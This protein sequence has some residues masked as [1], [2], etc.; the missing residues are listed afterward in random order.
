MTTSN[1]IF[2]NFSAPIR[3]SGIS[4][5][6]TDRMTLSGTLQKTVMLLALFS[7]GAAM[8]WTQH[9][10]FALMSTRD[11]KRVGWGVLAA[12]L[13]C[14]V[15]VVLTIF[16]K[17]WSLATAPVCALLEGSVVGFLPAVA[18]PEYAG[19]ALQV[20]FLTIAISLC[21]L[22]AY[23]FEV[24]RITDSLKKKL[25]CAIGGVLFYY[26]VNSVLVA[27]GVRTVSTS[28][29]W[30][31]S[32]CTSVMMVLLA[33]MSLISGFDFAVRYS[34]GVFPKYME[35]YAALGLLVALFWLYIEV[36]TLTLKARDAEGK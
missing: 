26:L 9:S 21:F 7:V 18:V 20:V 6:N 32:I 11:I 36:L 8:M 1:P 3:A 24:V 15:L 23:R 33:G 29:G 25:G 28:N 16:K 14:F 12:F 17:Q 10:S 4:A 2:R 35:W 13:T 34:A 19:I 31:P 27:A 5:K 22:A 30:G